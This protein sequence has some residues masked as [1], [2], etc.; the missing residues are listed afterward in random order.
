M[1]RRRAGNTTAGVP[2]HHA[3]LRRRG[4][5]PAGEPP[6]YPLDDDQARAHR[7][8]AGADGGVPQR[9][10]QALLRG[11]DGRPGEAGKEAVHFLGRSFVV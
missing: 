1:L 7:E 8:E 5:G 9:P 11:D 2:H 3:Q 4:A 6:R 10:E